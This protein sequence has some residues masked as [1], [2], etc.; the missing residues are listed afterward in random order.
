MEGYIS[1]VQLA[2]QLE[3][4]TLYNKKGWIVKVDTYQERELSSLIYGLQKAAEK[5]YFVVGSDLLESLVN[6]CDYVT[7]VNP[8][9]SKTS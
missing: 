2:S 9:G 3:L 8:C 6:I 7:P 5:G 4:V 1:K